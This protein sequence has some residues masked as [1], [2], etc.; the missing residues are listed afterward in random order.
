M[1]QNKVAGPFR[2]SVRADDRPDYNY[3]FAGNF[4][5]HFSRLTQEC[6]R[7]K[8]TFGL[9]YNANENNWNV[10]VRSDNP[11]EGY[12]FNGGSLGTVM[13]GAIYHAEERINRG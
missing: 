2:M 12:E 10:K 7:K 4:S 1:N 9:E 3:P 13:K 8:L 6:M 11:S 5:E